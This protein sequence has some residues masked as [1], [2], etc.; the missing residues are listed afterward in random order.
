MV[1]HNGRKRACNY[2]GERGCPSPHQA[3]GHA[4][5]YT[6]P[7]EALVSVAEAHAHVSK[8]LVGGRA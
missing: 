4:G 7:A 2:C 3:A 5:Y 8:Q 1:A 6:L